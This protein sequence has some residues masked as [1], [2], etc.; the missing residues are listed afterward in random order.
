MY[1]KML[2]L[3]ATAMAA[4]GLVACSSSHGGGNN[5]PGQKVTITVQGMPPTSDAAGRKT[6]QA[7]VA[8]FEQA[9]PNIKVVATDGAWDPQT[10]ASKLAGGSIETVIRVP[11]TEPQGLI[12]RQQ[13]EDITAELNAWPQ[14]TQYDKR[15]LGPSQDSSGHVYGLTEA[16]YTM[17]LVYNRSLFTKAGLDP[18]HP[19][20]TWDE[21]R[22]DAK[23]IH[24]KTGAAGYSETTTNNTGGWH[25]TSYTYSRGG[26]MET[27]QNGKTVAAFN[28]AP[29]KDALQFLHDMR[30]TDNSMGTNQLQNQMDVQRKFAA[31]Q[32]GMFIDAP[33]S[34]YPIVQQFGGNKN[35]FGSGAL[36]QGG[37]NATQL[38]GTAD[39]ITAK[40]SPAQRAAAVKWLVFEYMQP[41]YDPTIAAA[42]AKAMAADPKTLVGVP[43]LPAFSKNL[44]D[45]VN[46]AIKPYVNVPLANFQPYLDGNTGLK[47]LSEPPL[48]AQQLYAALDPVVQAVLTKKDANVDSLLS[49]AESQVNAQ[50]ASGQ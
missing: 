40:A 37:G 5:K 29:T 47:F 21:V 45:Q 13:V 24:D 11:L 15:I 32:V 35:D 48:D 8:A 41:Q 27:E 44:Q 50:L 2:V 14:F 18:D 19:P 49:K 7:Q 43:Q 31:G 1:S 25:L 42:N 26:T 4:T 16:Q 17:G 38:G 46:A 9:N 36:P 20:T 33:S 28:A 10:F 39:M 34:I 6:F 23:M 12:K 3:A 30:W 22:Q